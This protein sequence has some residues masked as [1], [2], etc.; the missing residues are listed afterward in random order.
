MAL[1]M[2]FAS[3]LPLLLTSR[4]LQ[5]WMTDENVSLTTIGF[6]SLAGLPYTLKFLWAPIFDRFT[7]PFLG[8][9]RGWIFIC[10]LGLAVSLAALA[11]SQPKQ[12]LW[13]VAFISI[14]ISFF[15][16][17]QDS[18]VDAYRRETLADNELGIGS[19]YYVYG[20]RAAMWISGGLAL[21]LADR[22]SWTTVY[23]LMAACMAVTMVTTWMADEPKLS[24]KT[25]KTLGEA[26][27]APLKEFFGRRE[28]W[29]ILAF[30]L[31]YKVGDT[32]AGAIATPFYLKIGFSKTEVG[33]IVKTFGFFSSLG[34]LFIGGLLILKM[35]IERSLIFFGILQ[36]LSTAGYAMLAIVGS[37]VLALT[38]VIAFEDLTGGMGTAAFTAYMAA[39]TDK[40]F[41][42]TQYALL[43][44]LMGVPRVVLSSFSGWMAES[45]G[46]V[47][48]FTF[49]TLIA[50]PG[51]LIALY[52]NGNLDFVAARAISRRRKGA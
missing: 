36:A 27:I 26:V 52:M 51:L 47:P 17:S 37:S 42:A 20:Y 4:T 29:L 6:F 34:G 35:G 45:M 21:M 30:I 11:L 13:F 22:L 40:R 41:T 14:V 2:G 38:W 12:D 9:R 25:P 15:S 48:F 33:V 32:M 18:V 1:L 49:C 24:A 5:A 43:T 28:A 44:S 39:Q 7:L 50:A 46:W 8:R 10:Q 19:S 16:A 3:G 31:L 23:L